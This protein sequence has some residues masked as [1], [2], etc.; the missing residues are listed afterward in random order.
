MSDE[1][2]DQERVESR[3]HLLPEEAAAG[4]DNA[5]AQADAILAE[6]DARE[7]DPNA[8]PDTVLERRTSDQTVTPIEPPD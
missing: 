5:L 6:S 4:S 7:A 1:L 2:S 8:A 3:A